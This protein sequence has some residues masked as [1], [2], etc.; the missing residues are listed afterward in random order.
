MNEKRILRAILFAAAAAALAFA[1]GQLRDTHRKISLNVEEIEDQ[2][3][4]LDAVT[5]A[6][7]VAR[8]TADAAKTVHERTG[9]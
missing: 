2:I 3:A 9:H 5:R 7:V 8:L 1:A 6:G 4:G